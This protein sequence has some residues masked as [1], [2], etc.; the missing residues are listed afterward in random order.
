M[1]R[2]L[3]SLF[4]CALA[5]VAAPSATALADHTAPYKGRFDFAVTDI[6]PVSATVS[7]I[8]GSLKGIE[9]HLGRFTGEVEY[10]VDWTTGAFAGSLTKT[11][12][13]GDLFSETLTGQFTAT[14]SEGKF[15]VSG[16]A[17]R[18]RGA[19]GGGTFL[20]VWTD[21]A[22]TTAH[23]T[24]DGTLSRPNV[25][26]YQAEGTVAFSNVQ[27][28]TQAGGLAPYLA[29]GDSDLIGKHTQAGSILNLSG[30]IPIDPTTL[31]FY[32][33]VGPNPFV[34]GHPKVHVIDTRNGQ[35]FCTWTAVFTLRIINAKGDAIFSGDGAFTVIG[36]T[37]RYKDASGTFTTLF[38][39]QPVPA[40]ANQAIADYEQS[41]EILRH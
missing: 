36:G 2:Y 25:G 35:I 33:E 34:T 31:I 9:T 11:A 17:G 30:L 41:G 20:G 16:G 18:F 39:T 6:Q 1:R 5:G 32:G 8:R 22:L 13:N 15:K 28:A 10:R 12:A 27:G 26:G 19:T 4:L 38:E 29:A 7:L 23:I 40:G 14:G 24:F 3:P 21:P 37:G